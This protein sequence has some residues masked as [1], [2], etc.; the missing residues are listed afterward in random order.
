MIKSAEITLTMA[1]LL[2]RMLFVTTRTME[3]LSV[4]LCL[5][6]FGDWCSVTKEYTANLC[7]VKKSWNCHPF[8][9]PSDK[10]CEHCTSLFFYEARKFQCSFQCARRQGLINGCTLFITSILLMLLNA[11]FGIWKPGPVTIKV[12]LAIQYYEVDKGT[13]RN[14]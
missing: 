1:P 14:Y 12:G 5:G 10:P 3:R 8:A 6:D 9:H 7:I 4:R 2:V 11:K 13:D